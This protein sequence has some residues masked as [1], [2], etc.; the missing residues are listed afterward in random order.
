[1]FKYDI[2]VTCP[3]INLQN[4]R[5]NA[6]KSPIN[7]QYY[8]GTTIS[9][10]CNSGYNLDTSAPGCGTSTTCLATGIWSHSPATCKLGNGN[11]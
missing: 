2:V 9:F 10:T 11:R 4:G 6:N 7:G 5:A 3:S 8:Y 1:M